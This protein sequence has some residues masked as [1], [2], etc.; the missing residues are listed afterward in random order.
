MTKL[1]RL[2]VWLGGAAFVMSLG[3]TA[4]SYLIA[5]AATPASPSVA[6][7]AAI[8]ASLFTVFALH[9]SLFA[10]EPIKQ[11]LAR[12]VRA[13][14]LRSV[15]V[16]TAS[17]LLL[18]VLALWEPVDGDAYRITGWGAWALGAL[19]LSGLWLIARAVAR[20]DPL[21]LAGIKPESARGELQVA[22]PYGWVRHPLYLG[23][24]LAV[25]GAAHMTGSRL[26]FAAIS[27]AYL[28]VAVPFEERSLRR[29]FGEEYARYQRDVRWRILPFVY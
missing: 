4:Y 19:Q 2:F 18:L 28:V 26:L 27:T 1:E 9:H 3:A 15:Y 11:R 12:Y 8:N 6:R 20:I 16:W 13:D 21:E 10:R 23:W 5:W 24:A 25:F 7:A 14:L 22:G 17:L 29:A